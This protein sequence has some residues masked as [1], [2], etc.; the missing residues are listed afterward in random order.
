MVPFIRVLEATLWHNWIGM[1]G[2]TFETTADALAIGCLLA[3][4]R[5]R[6]FGTSWYRRAVLA[7]WPSALLLLLGIAMSTR[8]RAALLLGQPLVNLAIVMGVDHCV[9]RPAGRVGRW[10]NSRPLVYVGTLSYSLYLWQQLFL[11]R[12]STAAAAAFPLNVV[13][14]G[15]CALLSYYLVERP[16]LRLRPRVE[17]ML[18]HR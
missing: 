16:T 11:N 13:L 2:L 3:L 14:A 6:L 9:R 15:V 8:Y 17:K 5:E 10:L 1:I 12:G 7:G 18:R 4:T